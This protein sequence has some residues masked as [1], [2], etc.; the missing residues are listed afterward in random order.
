[1][2]I[3]TLFAKRSMAC[4]SLCKLTAR[5]SARAADFAPIRADITALVV[6][7]AGTVHVTVLQ[8]F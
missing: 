5:A 1:M 7:S 6:M 4:P 8:F 2:H 3:E